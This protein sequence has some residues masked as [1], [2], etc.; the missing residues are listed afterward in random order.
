[1][2][3]PALSWSTPHPVPCVQAQQKP[4]LW[5]SQR[6]QP[7]L[8]QPPQ[9]QPVTQQVPPSEV[10]AP[11]AADGPD[12]GIPDGALDVDSL[13][14]TAE[15]IE[16]VDAGL[17]PGLNTSPSPSPSPCPRLTLVPSQASRSPL[18]YRR[19]SR[20]HIDWPP[21][22][23]CGGTTRCRCSGGVT[24]GNPSWD[25]Y[26]TPASNASKSVSAHLLRMHLL[27]EQ[28]GSERRF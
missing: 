8:L 16:K 24:L 5:Q 18:T 6:P 28:C 2:D 22:G 11:S 20:S 21:T 1:M 3:G 13:R 19:C 27:L 9:S 23:C 12:G 17:G 10:P 26:L 7:T 25:R 4:P 14:D 15:D